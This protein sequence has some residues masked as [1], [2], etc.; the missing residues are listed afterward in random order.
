[1]KLNK[2]ATLILI[3]LLPVTATADTHVLTFG[4]VALHEGSRFELC[5]NSK[6]A[7]NDVIVTASFVGIRSSKSI[8]REVKLF[9]G[10]GGCFRLNYEQA[11]D[12]PVFAAIEV[13][14]EPGDTDI[15]ASAAIV[16]G[17]FQSP[18]PQLL[19]QDEGRATATTF[20]PLEIPEDRRI[21]VCANNWKS[22]YTSDITINFYRVGDSLEPLLSKS[23]TLDPG[24]GGCVALSQKQA[25]RAAVIAELITSPV[26]PGFSNPVPVTGAYIINGIFEAPVPSQFRI[27]PDQ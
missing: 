1:M 20:G 2:L 22:E 10:E 9:P 24:Q 3:A 6:Y 4:P 26:E 23:H 19:Q 11:G 16:N 8:T 27:L 25:G 18:K 5:A 13:L 7:V 14:G 21:E 12:A 15:I 17:I